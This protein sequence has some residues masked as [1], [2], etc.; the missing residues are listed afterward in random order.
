MKRILKPLCL[1][2]FLLLAGCNGSMFDSATTTTST[3]STPGRTTTDTA[4]GVS[5]TTQ[6]ST[7]QTTTTLQSEACAVTN[8]TKEGALIDIRP[9]MH[10]SDREVIISIQWRSDANVSK[11][12]V[13]LDGDRLFDVQSSV[14]AGRT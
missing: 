5:S 1:V 10:G 7:T 4:I 8:E 2:L 9:T 12:A 3:H 14:L 11:L 13:T 6:S